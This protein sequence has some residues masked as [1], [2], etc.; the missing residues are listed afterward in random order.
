MTLEGQKHSSIV[1]KLQNQNPHAVSS[2]LSLID[3]SIL[4]RA[5]V[6]QFVLLQIDDGFLSAPAAVEFPT[7]GG[8]TAF[9]NYY[10]PHNKVRG[11][12]RKACT[13]FY[14]TPPSG[15]KLA[16]GFLKL[17]RRDDSHVVCC[18]A[19]TGLQAAA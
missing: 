18:T 7:E 6:I 19:I 10:P 4:E 13:T 9:M 14:N 1:R 3:S 5:A 16:S 8:L 2:T 11:P 12:T 17:P 15:G